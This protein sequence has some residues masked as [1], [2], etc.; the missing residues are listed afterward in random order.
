MIA[1][2]IPRWLGPAAIYA[3]V[4]WMKGNIECRAWMWLGVNCTWEPNA[5]NWDD[6][7]HETC[8]SVMLKVMK[9]LIF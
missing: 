1:Q 9:K 2:S 4:S 7:L 5:V 6:K 8:D 3:Q